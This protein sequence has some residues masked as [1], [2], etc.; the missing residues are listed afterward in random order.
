MSLQ[1]NEIMDIF[2][3]DYKTLS[4][5]DGITG[6]KSDTSL[7]VATPP[8]RAAVELLPLSVAGVSVIHRPQVQQ[9]QTHHMH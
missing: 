1:Q 9:G 3:D 4:D 6:N 5:T 7:K 8:H 2:I